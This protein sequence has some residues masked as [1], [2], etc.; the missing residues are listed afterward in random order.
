MSDNPYSN[1]PSKA[2]WRPSVA[3]RSYFAIEGLWDPKF[4]IRK[5]MKVSTYG[6]CF[7][8]H[9]G[10]ALRR[11]GFN[12]H[13]SETAPDSLSA[14][15]KKNFN[16]E[17]FSS[18]TGNIYTTSLLK[19][20]TEWALGESNPPEEYWTKDGRFYDPFRPAIEP[21]GFAS[22]E[23]MLASR[24]HA[25]ACF[26]DSFENVNVFVFT[27]GLTE[28]WMNKAKGY[29]YPMC[30]GTVAGEFDPENHVFENMT[31]NTVRENLVAAIKLMRSVNPRLRFI[32]TV[33]P[34][35]LTASASGK[36]VLVATMQSKSI[37]RAAAGQLA[38]KIKYIDYFP[39]YEI[40]NSPVFRGSFFAPNMRSVVPEGV[41][42]VMNG[43]FQCQQETF[44]PQ[45]TPE[46]GGYEAEKK[47][48]KKAGKK[49]K[50]QADDLVCEEELLAAFEDGRS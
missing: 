28:L 25:L 6:S 43:F 20:W 35:P 23:E 48:R 45:E 15:S 34:V 38:D 7:A 27:L 29:E 5:G 18:R 42:F 30:P 31:V 21:E 49:A 32:L 36:H 39:S 19:Q 16:Y 44:G 4:E 24:A 10:Q 47:A 46:T 11:R 26:R 37:L 40:I 17:I 13:I 3:D 14:Q 8:Q 12:W 33:S 1:L 9:I 2:F 22:L 41:E 50:A